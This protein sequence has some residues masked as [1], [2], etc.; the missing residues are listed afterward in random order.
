MPPIFIACLLSGAKQIASTWPASVAS[1]QRSSTCSTERPPSGCAVLRLTTAGSMVSTARKAGFEV[2]ARPRTSASD[3]TGAS[4]TSVPAMRWP[5]CHSQGS[6]T[7]TTLAS[8]VA[9]ALASR[10]AISSAPMP[11]GSPSVSATTGS[12]CGFVSMR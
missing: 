5:S 4:A 3:C 12:D 1:M 7:S 11:A 9:S 8:V 6:P 10:R 2:S